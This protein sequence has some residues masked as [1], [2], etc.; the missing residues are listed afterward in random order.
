MVLTSE[1][2]QCGIGE[3][4][5]IV[6]RTPFSTYGYLNAS[7]GDRHGFAAN[8]FGEDRSD[9]IYY[10]GDLG[11]YR[12]D[13]TLEILGRLDDQ[14]KVRGVRVEPREVEA[15]LQRHPAVKACAVLGFKDE[16]EETFLAAYVVASPG[17]HM[18]ELRSFLWQQLPAAMAPTAFIFLDDLPLNI[19]GKVDRKALPA[20]HGA[21]L[22]LKKIYVAPRTPLEEALARI[23]AELL[24]QEQIGVH[25][26]FF[27]LGGHSLLAT[28][29]ISQICHIS[30]INL[31]LRRLFEDPTVAGLA[32]HVQLAIS[33]GLQ[34][35]MPELLPV[36][37][38]EKLPLSFAQQRLWFLD[39]WER[40]SSFYNVSTI[41][42]IRG[43]LQMEALEQ[44]INEILRRHEALRTTFVEEQGQPVQRIALES[45]VEVGVTDLEQLPEQERRAEADRLAMEETKRP[46]DLSRGPLFRARVFRLD[47]QEHVLV[48]V[49]HHIVT[50][51]W[52]MG[53]FFRELSLLYEA[54]KKKEPSPLEDLPIQYADF[55]IWQRQWLRGEV[56]EREVE[57]WKERLEGLAVLELPTDRARP[58]VMSYRGARRSFVLSE[59]LVEGLKVLSREEGVTLFMTLL[60]AFQ[61]L[62][63][64]YSGQ[65][66]IGVGSPIANRNQ[67]EIE[68]LI[69]FFVNTLVLRIDV[70]GD[71]SFRELM[72]RVREVALGAYAHQDLPFEKLVEEIN[73]DRDAS[74]SPLFQVMLVLENA[75]EPKPELAG[76]EVESLEG[77]TETAKF[78]LTLFLTEE[79]GRLRGIFEYNTDLFE[80]STME[81]MIGHW[82]TLLE[83]IV[84]N[85]DQRLSELPILTEDERHRL[86]VEWNDT[87]V[88]YPRDACIHELF[89]RQVERTPEAVAVVFGGE[90]LT[91]RELNA[92]ANQVAHYL[93]GR[94]VGPE[95]LVGVCMERS[96]EMVVGL[97]GILKAGAAYVPLD[98]EYPK[99]RLAFMIRDTGITL[100]MTHSG[101]AENLPGGIPELLRLDE[102]G[103]KLNGESKQNLAGSAGAG[104][105]AYVMYTS[106]STGTPKGVEVV[107][108]GIVRLV[109]SGSYARLGADETFLQLAPISF[110]ASTLELWA[111]LLRGGRCV[112][113]PAGVPSP[114]KLGEVIRRQG[115]STL[116]LTASLF[117]VIVTEAP[118]SL[119]GVRQLLIGGEQLSTPHV[120]RAQGQLKDTQII[121]GYGPTEN[122]TF[123]CCYAIPEGIA[124]DTVLPIGRPIANTQVYILDQWRNPV[125]VGIPGE[126]YVGGDGLARGYLNRPELTAEAFIDD[127]FSSEPGARLYRTG[128]VVRYRPDGNIEFLGRMD[129]QVKI[130]GYRIE[131]GEIEAV[132]R[133]HEGIREAAVQVREDVPGDKRLVA[134]V[135]NEAG[136]DVTVGGLRIFMKQRLPEYM[137]PSMYVTLE[138]MPLTASGKVNRKA[139]P[140]PE[141]IRP[142][143]EAGYAAP[144]TSVE[145]AMAGIWA[146]LLG[147][148]R[149]GI[150]DNFFELGG[151]SLL[152]VRLCSRIAERFGEKLPLSTFFRGPTVESVAKTL[153][154]VT[155]AGNV[156]ALVEIRHTGS[157]IPLYVLHDL[158]GET[159]LANKL[160]DYL[161]IDLSIFG[162]YHGSA[163]GFCDAEDGLEKLAERYVHDILAFQPNG[164][165]CL[166]GYSFGGHL[167]YEVARQ[168]SFRGHAV[169]HLGIID[170]GP[171]TKDEKSIRSRFT[172]TLNF[173]RN[174]PWWVWDDL[175]AIGPAENAGRV[176]RKIRQTNK[177][178]K[179]AVMLRAW[180]A[181]GADLEDIFELKEYPHE[182][183]QIMEYHLDLLRKYRCHSYA[184]PLTL[185]R[186]RAQSLFHTRAD[187]LGWGE[188]VNGPIE[189]VEIS[190]NHFNIVKEPRIRFLAEA[191]RVRMQRV[192]GNKPDADF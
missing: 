93:R 55:A 32:K 176:C 153:K 146:E 44:S 144:R 24:G 80:G 107:H 58:A 154:Q 69:G 130:R 41:L 152:A 88:D 103:E 174:F 20:P 131:L 82:E 1:G 52:S 114:E 149:V 81:R 115:V 116:W 21:N 191:L 132:L 120:V 17:T 38:R 64:R 151:H 94:G 160:A 97:L 27:D 104:D 84:A 42:H 15:L 101:V 172:G 46:F 91:Y 71:P 34:A 133:Q 141:G 184:G 36:A 8:P 12:P 74:R 5:E 29:V 31:P 113:Y 19:N 39:L 169:G 86:L 170:T 108:R 51:G 50:D 45:A 175:L 54:Y 185:Y 60:A 139:L 22:G 30:Q 96:L 143:G 110:D 159:L 155:K 138:A 182:Y 137:V 37:N 136:V 156:S 18:Q 135:A 2:Q 90:K 61:T 162:F 189:V 105:L 163:N 123:T 171:A 59:G 4:G 129:D 47:E 150:H 178:M 53:V 100:L 173:L 121:N 161:G 65:E 188:F 40:G 3:L 109:M 126:L 85:P 180:P 14:I 56:L 168:L 23:W 35:D 73:P 6:I 7:P 10:T 106:G 134:Y 95:V 57:Y 98:P 148:E 181:I 99:E 77:R 166:A 142:E 124:P 165:Y 179:K 87:K 117:N 70:G 62:L 83:G 102:E 190:G 78:D 26:N 145:E 177:W 9:R 79:E 111:P 76:L 43:P 183:V 128:D 68:G 75:P 16:K 157:G 167:A 89:E 112:V 118:E 147:L 125:P 164:P 13:G 92:R 72:G 122:T 48:L 67:V 140:A 11:R 192:A 63:H 49:M 119:L 66:D 28:Q 186:A 158:G 187:D 25:D 127:P 33:K